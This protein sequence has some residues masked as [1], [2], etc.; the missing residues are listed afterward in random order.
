MGLRYRAVQASAGPIHRLPRALQV[1]ISDINKLQIQQD[2]GRTRNKNDRT[3]DSRGAHFS[4]WSARNHLTP[5]LLSRLTDNECIHILHLYLHH[6][7][8]GENYYR[9]SDLA[10]DTIQSYVTAAHSALQ[11]ALNRPVN[12]S[13]PTNSTLLHPLLSDSLQFHRRWQRPRDRKEP[14]TD[15]I[16]SVLYYRAVGAPPSSLDA[17]LFDWVRLGLFTGSRASEFAQTSGSKFVFAAVPNCPND[18]SWNDQPIAFVSSDF[19]FLTQAN[20]MLPLA[21]LPKHEHT[22]SAVQIRFRHDKSAH[23]FTKRIFRRSGHSYLCPVLASCSIARRSLSLQ[24]GA[25]LPLASYQVKPGKIA[26]LRSADI[27]KALRQAC[28]E[29]YPNPHN[30]HRRHA[31]L[32]VAHSTRVTA[33]VALWNVQVPLPQIAFRLRWQEDSIKHYLRD[34]SK[35][36][37]PHSQAAIAGVLNI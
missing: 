9:R 20:D 11:V 12:I 17:T 25:H 18:P 3:L 32:L 10:A 31:H 23:N 29:A 37:G 16:L 1:A 33:A 35:A 26:Y 14:I 22:V 5:E 4:R 15:A 24:V 19:V 36:I 34:C 13:N 30:Y 27:I 8:N 6:V 28:L 7:T 2:R 21:S